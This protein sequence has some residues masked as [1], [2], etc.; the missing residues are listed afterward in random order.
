MAE[1][2]FT[3]GWGNPPCSRKW[4]YFPANDGRSLCGKIGL[5]FPDEPFE[6]GN[7]DSKSNCAE[8]R[9]LL[10]KEKKG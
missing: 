10:A 8:C 2:K 5:Y 6:Q 3:P 4:H 7:D 1:K 9:K